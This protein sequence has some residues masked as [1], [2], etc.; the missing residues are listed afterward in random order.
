ME[1]S[2]SVGSVRTTGRCQTWVGAGAASSLAPEALGPS[3]SV[4]PNRAADTRARRG[5]RCPSYSCPDATR[6]YSRADILRAGWGEAEEARHGVSVCSWMPWVL[7]L[8]VFPMSLP[9]ALGTQEDDFKWFRIVGVVHLQLPRITAV[10][11]GC[12]A[13][14]AACQQRPAC[15]LFSPAFFW[16]LDGPSRLRAR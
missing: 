13:L 14:N 9:V 2:A 12:L 16:I 15:L 10:L 3:E 1:V 4:G 11:A 6:R 8:V 5:T 7:G